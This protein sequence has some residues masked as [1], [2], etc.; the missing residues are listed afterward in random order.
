MKKL[1]IL[2]FL[3]IFIK[4]ICAQKYQPMVIENVHWRIS[5]T[6]FSEFKTYEYF[7]KGDTL[8]NDNLYKK[9]Y[10]RNFKL[11]KEDYPQE[12]FIPYQLVSEELW[13]GVR[14]DTTEKKVYVYP[15]FSTVNDRCHGKMINPEETLLYDFSLGLGETFNS[16]YLTDSLE[17]RVNEIDKVS[18]YGLERTIT[19]FEGG[20]GESNGEYI[21]EGI[22]AESGL[23]SLLI[24]QVSSS[25]LF[26]LADYCIGTDKDCNIITSAQQELNP[27]FNISPNPTRDFLFVT[28]IPEKA[29]IRIYN[30]IG[31]LQSVIPATST[32]DV[33]TFSN[34]TYILQILKKDILYAQTLFIKI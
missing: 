22:G 12:Y 30:S 8:I 33:S 4:T 15:F 32:I 13:A 29:H 27:I 1:F 3:L 2:F 5:E 21:I 24:T 26:S 18:I 14:E 10:L 23:F 16:C 19:G 6:C 25:C 28:N 20:T 31:K 7:A 11:K 34:G 9:I 17:L